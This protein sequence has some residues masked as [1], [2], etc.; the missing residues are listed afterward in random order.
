MPDLSDGA[1][2]MLISPAEVSQA[3][4]TA[5]PEEGADLS[6]EERTSVIDYMRTFTYVP[7]WE[8]PFRA[9]DG[10]IEGAIVKGGPGGEGAEKA[11]AVLTFSCAPS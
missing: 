10:V 11:S 1:R 4:R 9:A 3:W 6:D 7:P 5:H 2:M 8:S